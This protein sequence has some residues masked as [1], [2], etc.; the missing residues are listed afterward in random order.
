VD[1]LEQVGL[2]GFSKINKVVMGYEYSA[3][4]HHRPPRNTCQN[5]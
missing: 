3:F 2:L 1:Q 5:Y 4:R